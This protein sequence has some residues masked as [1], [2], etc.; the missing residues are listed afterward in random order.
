MSDIVLVVIVT[1][2]GLVFTVIGLAAYRRHS[3][4]RKRQ[5]WWR[6]NKPYLVRLRDRE[7]LNIDRAL[8]R[9]Y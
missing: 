6:N 1:A 3:D 8:K 2:A 4:R 5:E 7:P 9:E